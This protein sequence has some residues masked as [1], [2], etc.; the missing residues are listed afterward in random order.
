MDAYNSFCT[1]AISAV[2]VLLP[3]RPLL[4]AVR[5]LG[6]SLI[7]YGIFRAFEATFPQIASTNE[8]HYANIV[9]VVTVVIV[10]LANL[11]SFLGSRADLRDDLLWNR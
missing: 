10:S 6:Y 9:V 4:S 11:I 3:N 7:G 5:P 2:M 8:F 1:I